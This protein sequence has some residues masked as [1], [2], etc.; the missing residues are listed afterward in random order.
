M[1]FQSGSWNRTAIAVRDLRAKLATRS[2][3]LETLQTR[4]TLAGD[5]VAS[6]ALQYTGGATIPGQVA[7]PTPAP[8]LDPADVNVNGV[9]TALDA[10]RVANAIGQQLT[11]E[12]MPRADIDHDQSISVADFDLVIAAIQSHTNSSAPSVNEEPA[13]IACPIAGVMNFNMA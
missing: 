12:Q 7:G 3:R 6:P 9:I 2:L 11:N 4:R 13:P 5:G 1:S 8:T 10:L